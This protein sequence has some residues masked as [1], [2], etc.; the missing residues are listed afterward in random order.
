MKYDDN[1]EALIKKDGERGKKGE[2]KEKEIEMFEEIIWGSIA[3]VYE[4]F[5]KV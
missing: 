3:G 2:R 1:D 5:N 4:I